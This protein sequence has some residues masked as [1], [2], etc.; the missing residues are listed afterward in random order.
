MMPRQGKGWLVKKICFPAKFEFKKKFSSPCFC[1]FP[2]EMFVSQSKI[3]TTSIKD[4]CR[5]F[6]FPRHGICNPY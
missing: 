4:Y 6:A 5:D 3:Y 1:C 2:I